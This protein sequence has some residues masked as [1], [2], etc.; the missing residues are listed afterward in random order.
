MF[1][2]LTVAAVVL[3]AS[4]VTLETIDGQKHTGDLTQLDQQQ[5]VIKTTTDSQTV[6]VEQILRLVNDDRPDEGIQ[7]ELTIWL[8]DGSV[9]A[10]TSVEL[11]NELAKIGMQPGVT[12][13]LDPRHLHRVR[14]RAPGDPHPLDQSWAEILGREHE[15]D[16]VVI[17]KSEQVLD[18]LE[19][20]IGDI[21]VEEVG[22]K[23]DGDDFNVKRS[24]LEGFVFLTPR[25]EQ[26]RPVRVVRSVGNSSWHAEEIRW[27]G[28]G[29]EMLLTCGARIR[30][31]LTSIRA[32]DYA[33]TR[34][35]Y[36]SSLEPYKLTV[37]P[38][39]ASAALD[40]LT[41]RLIYNPGIDQ[42]LS[43]GR[44][45]LPDKR[46]TQQH[47]Y[48]DRGLALH[49]RTELIYRLPDKFSQLQGIAGLDPELRQRGQVRLLIEGDDRVLLDQPL[50]A[51][52]APLPINLDLSGVQR[53]RILV[54]YG[55]ELDMAD[56]L[57]LCE[58]RLTP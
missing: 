8:T 40:E 10:A 3:G 31:P 46:K 6:D 21:T 18:Y 5:A 12:V 57:N 39:L 30:L 35:V 37:T 49:S 44:L 38:R 50:G 7:P 26:R 16:I 14:F 20:A 56:H 4:T 34:I 58:M 33:A 28:Q 41:R 11:Q 9:L 43:G 2:I 45:S 24:K 23:F 47:L 27:Q 32:I 48:Y 51:N 13:E 54:D 42:N 55:D 22:F 25:V 19:G 1:V 53:L 52:D 36:L 17:R 29:V 15:G